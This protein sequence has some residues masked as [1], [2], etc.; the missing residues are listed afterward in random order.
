LSS[1]GSF[2]AGGIEFALATTLRYRLH[3]SDGCRAVQ[4]VRATLAT[5][6]ALLGGPAGDG[7]L[8]AVVIAGFGGTA[9]AS[10]AAT[11]SAFPLG[12]AAFFFGGFKPSIATA[13]AVDTA[14]GGIPAFGATAVGGIPAFGVG[15][16]NICPMV[17]T[18]L[19]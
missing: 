9:S 1:A 12:D 4:S 19:G 11:A 14:V 2:A 10:G 15:A 8:I 18:A 16:T 3:S 17:L 7:D 13:S 6:P 5:D